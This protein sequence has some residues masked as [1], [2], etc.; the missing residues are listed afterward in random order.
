MFDE[1]GKYSN[2]GHFFF[3][4]GDTLAN[5]SKEVPDKPGVFYIIR[6][7]KGNI[8]L[9]YIGK[10]SPIKTASGENQ[11]S[12]KQS[13]N[14]AKNISRQIYFDKKMTSEKIDGLDIYWFVTV[15]EEFN[16]APKMVEALI[17]KRY[18]E[19]YGSVPKWNSL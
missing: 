16:D 1:T 19:V 7:A 17:L 10:S 18:M 3:Q 15:D 2:N 13:I 12:I 4:K 5:V 11:E 14:M 8:D 6:L 9:V